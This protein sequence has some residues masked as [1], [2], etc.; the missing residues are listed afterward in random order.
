M[1]KFLTGFI[2]LLFVFVFIFP[3]SRV[4]AQTPSGKEIKI[5]QEKPKSEDVSN[6]KEGQAATVAAIVEY[7]L[8]YPGILP[9]NPLYFLKAARDRLVGFLI[10]DSTKKAE[11]NLLTSDKRINAAWLLAAK[12]KN[13]LSVSTLSKSNNYID[14]AILAASIAKNAG[15]NVDTVLSNL[16][17]AI[18]KHIEVVDLIEKKVDKKFVPQVQ[19]E[20]KRLVEFGRTVDKLLP[21]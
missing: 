6:N 20:E 21:Q 2:C 19:R 5:D 15:K 3:N 4:S 12:G 11:F 10:S 13:D 18:T 17:N 16:K 8:P 14:Q 7:N 9:D 1:R